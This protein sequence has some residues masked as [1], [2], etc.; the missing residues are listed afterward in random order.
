M[1]TLWRP[2]NSLDSSW[3]K[4]EGPRTMPRS[5]I[6]RTI[7]PSFL[8]P[9]FMRSQPA[10]PCCAT[11]LALGM[12]LLSVTTARG[13][14]S[15]FALS[16]TVGVSHD[17]N[18]LRLTDAQA[19]PAGRSASDTVYTVG[20][21]AALDKPISRQRLFG[22]AQVQATRYGRN[23]V[24]NDTGYALKLGLDW[25][26]V[27]RLSGNVTVA[28]Q[29]AQRPN[30]RDVS[31]GLIVT[32]NAESTRQFDTRIALG[33]ATRMT[34][35]ATYGH[36][37]LG[38]GAPGSRFR[39]YTQ[40]SASVGLRYQFS[41]ALSAGVVARQARLSYPNLLV[42]LPDPE[43]RRTRNDVGL[44]STWQPTG[45]STVQAR[46]AFTNTQHE[47][48]TSRDFK[49]TT[50]GIE[51]LWNPG[52]RLRLE[53]RL[54]RDAGQD[55]T[56]NSTAFSRTTDLLGLRAQ[57]ALGGKTT[58]QA[59]VNSIRRTQQGS[60]GV[61]QGVAGSDNASLVHLRVVWAPT[62]SFSFSCDLGR[63]RRGANSSPQID[64]SFSSN[65]VGCAGQLTLN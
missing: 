35:E 31:D 13:E 32:D 21:Q 22:N 52:G 19:A 40:D 59:T 49:A 44:Q 50:G 7:A 41:G 48:L 63:E 54:A 43:D 3:R 39:D 12:A 30:L 20:L 46:L 34:L 64:E 17:S 36:R 6:S 33:A 55:D 28:A 26:T 1:D 23:D 25:E 62:R 27:H 4:S 65:T 10:A 24:Y 15:P 16:T 57:Y 60:G 51:W 2:Q 11:C 45:S 14:V 58:L 9:V 53:V 47:Q 61:L 56:L 18:L 8:A 38:Y 42:L 5:D 29:R 37:S